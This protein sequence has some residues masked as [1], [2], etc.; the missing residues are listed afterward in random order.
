[1]TQGF[2]QSID[3]KQTKVGTMYDITI[4][5]RRLGAGK[6]PPKGFEA[7]DY[8]NYEAEQRGNFL[9]LKAGSMSKATPP[10]GV[11]APQPAPVASSASA[12]T[13]AAFAKADAKDEAYSRGASANTAIALIKILADTGS[14][15]LPPKLGKD[16]QADVIYA[17]FKEYTGRVY[18]MTTG[19]DFV[20]NDSA[21][22]TGGSLSDAEGDDSWVE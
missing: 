18:K 10:A 7:G 12:N 15:P 14:L 3:A 11:P 17:I 22:A 9:N 8:V 16:K 13:S 6:F 1:M 4:D 20:D 19:R 2:I 21:P 5:G